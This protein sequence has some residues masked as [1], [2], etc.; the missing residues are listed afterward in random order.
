M[1]SRRLTSRKDMT[2]SNDPTHGRSYD[3]SRRDALRLSGLS[4]LALTAAACG[5]QGEATKQTTSEA[6]TAADKFWKAQKPT[7]QVT[8]ANW[9]LYI[10]PSRETL[11]EFTAKT[12]IKV[13]YEEVIQDDDSFFAKISP[14]LKS[15][16]PTGYDIMVITDGLEFNELVELGE[17]IPLDQSKLT[18]FRT[19]AGAS[20]RKR[21]F[22]PGNVYSVPWAAGSTGI[23]WNPKYVTT[24]PTSI[25]DL[26]DP[27][28]KGHVGMM[29]DTQ[30]IANFGLIKLGINPETSTEADWKKAAAVLTQQKNE[31]IVR[32]YYDQSY[33]DALANGDT[34]ISMAWSGDIFQENISS[35]TNLQFTVP[36]EG[37]TLWMD[38]MMIPKYAKNPVAAME[39]IDWFYQPQIAAL[40]TEA[41][42][43]IS[44]VP[45]V[46]GII[47]D[48]A[49][50]AKGSTKTSL[51][52]VA[53]S[54]LV[55]LSAADYARL[56]NYVP[57]TSKNND[58][59]QTVFQPVVAG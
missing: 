59:F 20:Y 10:D 43:Y 38:N 29:S 12:G 34:W 9:S 11:K 27:K 49:A 53:A 7:G 58:S 25:N 33:I 19:Y 54:P 52:Q 35:G 37:G 17:V 41:I 32:Q 56:K 3:L 30:E 46:Q 26:W 40:L 23:A 48:A 51:E 6:E 57:L 31:G 4:A 21:S 45:S 44:P 22:D 55:W 24:P 13:T 8:F 50:K 14:V 36:K 28:Y 16:Q 1:T 5:V 15:G 2:S 42:D 18:N 47:K 39:L